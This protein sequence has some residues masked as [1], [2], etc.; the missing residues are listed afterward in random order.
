MKMVD[1]QGLTTNKVNTQNG[2]MVNA[3]VDNE[4][5]EGSGIT[6]LS[7]FDGISCGRQ[8]LKELGI[9]IDNYY[10]SEIDKYAIDVALK[11]HSD[12]IE[13]GDVEKWREW[14]L[15]WNSI[16][17][18]IGGSP[19]Q[20]FS[21][22]GK[23]LYFEDVRSKLIF[24]FIDI[25]NHVKSVNPNVRFLLENVKMNKRCK[26]LIDLCLG[27]KGVQINSNLFSAQNRN[28]I[29]WTNLSIAELPS[30]NGTVLKDIIEE[31]ADDEPKLYLTKRH[32]GGFLKSYKWKPN[33]LTEK[34]MPL[35][36]S[37]HKQPPHCPYIPRKRKLGI[38]EYSDYRRLSPT[39][40]E[41]LQTLPI[42]YTE[43]GASGNAISDSQR[44]KM[45]GNGWTVGAVKHIFSSL[46]AVK[47][48]IGYK[49][50]INEENFN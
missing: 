49:T 22:C 13:L 24:C 35:L 27:V 34:S 39:E 36:A 41:R 10:A 12:I 32:L 21:F 38:G 46:K 28:R 14:D 20:G 31:D 6:V 8:A 19:C 1:V 25:L 42:G 47:C 44:Y 5:I 30:G 3:K 48:D 9:K 50:V 16:D 45:I 11:N 18:I 40:C 26:E 29:Y 43:K 33:L 23:K 2:A 37:Y 7:L 17:L 15:D 4:A